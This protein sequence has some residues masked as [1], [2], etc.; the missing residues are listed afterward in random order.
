MMVW[1]PAA[2]LLIGL[3]VAMPLPFSG[4]W[5][6]KGL[7]SMKNLTDPVGVPLPEFGVTVAV[8]VMLWPTTDG[9]NEE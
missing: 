6:P 3:L 8:K 7:P 5:L 9:L 1:L 2:R 4:T